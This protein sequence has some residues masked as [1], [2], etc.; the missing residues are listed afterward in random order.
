MQPLGLGGR[1]AKL[2]DVM[3]NR[4]MARELRPY[5]PIVA[6]EKHAVW[7][8]GQQIDER[9]RVTAESRKIWQMRC[10]RDEE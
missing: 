5:W 1:S 8:V 6:N 2:K 3:I 9:A 10:Y 4:K 7:L